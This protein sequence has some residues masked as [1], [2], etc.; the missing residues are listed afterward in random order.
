[1]IHRAQAPFTALLLI[2]VCH[3]AGASPA[4]PPAPWAYGFKDPMPP[5]AVPATAARLTD[6]AA[7]KLPDFPLLSLPGT[8]RRFTP[9]E[10]RDNFAPADWY[11]GDH[12]RMPAIVAHGKPPVVWA[13]ARCHYPNGQGRP[14]NAPIAGLPADYFIEQMQAFRQGDRRSS[15]VRKANTPLMVSFAEAMTDEEIR[16]A[17]EYFA[18]IKFTPWIRVVETDRV[19]ATVISAGMFLQAEPRA[20]EPIDGRIIEVPEEP[21]TVEVQ[22]NPRIGFIAWVP[23]GSVK[24]G[25]LLVTTGGGKTVVCFACHGPE[26]RGMTLSEVGAMPGLAGRSPSYLFRQLFDIRTG[27][28]QGKRVELMKPVVANLS[29]DDLRDIAAYL[30]SRTP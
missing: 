2:G 17:A 24:R 21:G 29:S 15:D 9:A 12:P 25:E 26:L 6:A 30:A 20:D 8:E 16:A 11:P 10:I 7:I 19:P 22:R 3:A 28:R 23:V 27:R 5:N 1:M 13:C 14:E 18:S 4:E